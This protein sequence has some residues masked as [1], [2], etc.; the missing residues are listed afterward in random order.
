MDNYH[1]A[2]CGNLVDYLFHDIKGKVGMIVKRFME[3]VEEARP[4]VKE[5]LPWDLVPELDA[6]EPL[7]L[8]DIREPYEFDVVHI[9]NSLN[10]PRGILEQAC[11]TGY[12]ETVARL[13][14]AREE[15][16]VIICRSGHRSVLA[17]YVMQL[18]GFRQVRS[19]KL[20]L[21]GWNDF[22]LPLLDGRQ[23]RVDT[24]DAD[25]YFNPRQPV[26]PAG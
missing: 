7:L 4:W 5:V 16:V 15:N 13:A 10:V 11:E 3:L 8:L 25:R 22:E 1:P 21:R 24:D 9:P 26:R 19:L 6:G 2:F 20:G 12:E 18:M 14:A 17:G 23:Q